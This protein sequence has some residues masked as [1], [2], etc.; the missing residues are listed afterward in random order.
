MPDPIDIK[1]LSGYQVEL[2][3]ACDDGNG[4]LENNEVSIFNEL[5]KITEEN[6]IAPDLV[7]F[8]LSDKVRYVLQ[9]YCKDLN[10]DYNALMQF[11]EKLTNSVN[12]AI[13]NI[14]V[15]AE[16]LK[17]LPDNNGLPNYNQALGEMLSEVAY[18][19]RIGFRGKCARYVKNAIYEAGLGE[20]AT[21]HA[22]QM[23][24]I[25]DNNPNFTRVPD[26]KLAEIDV[27]KLPPGCVIVFNRG[28]QNYSK[29]YGHVEITLGDGRA[30]SDGV[31]NNL[32]QP[33][34]VFYPTTNLT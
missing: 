15:P 7:R 33:D 5:V 34:A 23:T 18:G 27:K 30:V 11:T 20:Y 13:E 25:L 31:T 1:N 29:S 32:R 4:V 16:A 28:S 26:E 3:K 10:M 24:D 21:G 22:Y 14:W 8:T 17:N 9:K 19:N 6:S 12:L 2:A